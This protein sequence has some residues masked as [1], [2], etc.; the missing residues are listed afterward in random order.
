MQV[1][2]E[3]EEIEEAAEIVQPKL[4]SSVYDIAKLGTSDR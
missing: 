2:K 3:E 4:Y 1:K